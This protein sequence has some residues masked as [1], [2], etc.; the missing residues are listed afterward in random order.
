MAKHSLV[1]FFKCEILGLL[2]SESGLL[3]VAM[4]C[5]FSRKGQGV[6]QLTYFIRQIHKGNDLSSRR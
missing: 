1:N 3:I 5:V 4:V 2:N 6:G